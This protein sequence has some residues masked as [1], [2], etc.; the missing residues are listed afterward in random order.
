MAWTSAD[1][2]DQIAGGDRGADRDFP[3]RLDHAAADFGPDRPR[4]T[5]ERLSEHADRAFEILELDPAG[6]RLDHGGGGATIGQNQLRRGHVCTPV[7]HATPVCR[8]MLEPKN[9]EH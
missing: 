2:P 5:V 6:Y 7:T 3:T 1:D 9:N 4:R 8:L